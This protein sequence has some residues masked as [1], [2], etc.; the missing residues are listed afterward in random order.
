MSHRGIMFRYSMLLV[1][2]AGLLLAL[3]A[4]R[5]AQAQ[6]DGGKRD[7]DAE[8]QA[9]FDRVEADVR[10]GAANPQAERMAATPCV[11][12]FAG[13]D[14]CDNLDL[15]ALRPLNTLGGGPPFNECL[16]R[17]APPAGPRYALVGRW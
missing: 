10:A 13:P 3:G 5:G 8:R 12:G 16:A 1:L 2:A 17:T 11:G 9:Y 4:G 15:T 7:F 14:A 6:Q